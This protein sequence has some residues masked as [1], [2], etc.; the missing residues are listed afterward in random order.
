MF[1][2]IHLKITKESIANKENN[3]KESGQETVD[4]GL[5]LAKVP[6]KIEVE[7]DQGFWSTLHPSNGRCL[8]FLKNKICFSFSV[9]SDNVAVSGSPYAVAQD[10]ANDATNGVCL[11][12]VFF[13]F[14]LM[15]SFENF[16]SEEVI[17]H[18]SKVGWCE[19]W[20]EQ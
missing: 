6:L 17:K 9:C 2:A 12:F 11:H 18:Q 1:C 8:Y 19:N 3:I 13:V 14:V 15:L 16:G 7:K 20:I 5:F 4:I 10:K